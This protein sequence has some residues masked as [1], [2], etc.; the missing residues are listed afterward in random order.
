MSSALDEKYQ[1]MIRPLRSLLER[2]APTAVIADLDRREE[3]PTEIYAELA[4]AGYTGLSISPEYGGSAADTTTIA[5]VAEELAK[6]GNTLVAAWEPT[7]AFSASAFQ[8]FG[9]EEQK[10]EILPGI[11]NGTIRLGMGLSEPNAGSDLSHLAAT[12]TP[13]GSDYLISGVKS[14]VTGG[15]TAKY[16]LIFARTREG[17]ARTSLTIFLVPPDAPGVSMRVDPKLCSQGVHLCTITLDR[18]RV[19]RT[20]ILGRLHGATGLVSR[21]LDNERIFTGAKGVG[22]AQAALDIA[23]DFAEKREAFGQ[24]IIE[25]QA[26]GHVIADMASEVE[27][28]RLLVLKAASLRD[29]GLDCS[30]EAS[31]AK[32]IGSVTGTRCAERG[33]QI[34]GGFSYLVEYGMERLYREA[35]LY[36]IGGGTSQIQRN[37]ILRMLRSQRA[38]S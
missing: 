13:D 23:F 20:A 3:F 17:P 8:H 29:A 28:A 16:N 11:A 31:M 32:L 35:K 7:C 34:L 37:I 10:R 18:V 22:I 19:P 26:V 14:Y 15:D 9:T 21:L 12:A 27:A 1:N 2:S 33:M 24:Q 36:E 30:K 5:L 38:A 6:F 4:A 25:F